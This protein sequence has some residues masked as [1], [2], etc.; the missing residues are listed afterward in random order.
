MQTGMVRRA[1]QEHELLGDVRGT[2]LMV[3]VE[4]VDGAA[5]RRHAPATAHWL[6]ETMLKR[7][8]LLATEGP[9]GNVIKIKPPMCFAV[10]EAD[11]VVETLAQARPGVAERL[12]C[13]LTCCRLGHAHGWVLGCSHFLR[14]G[15]FGVGF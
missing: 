15:T 13:Q 4:I 2:G 3:G 12:P 8:V 10:A 5:T 9:C 1:P 11:H 6:R 14:C 7:R